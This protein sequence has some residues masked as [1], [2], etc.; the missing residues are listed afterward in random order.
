MQSD[1]NFE[2]HSSDEVM[3]LIRDIVMNENSDNPE[4]DED[5]CAKINKLGINAARRTVAKYRG[6]M[7]IPSS[8]KRK[9]ITKLKL[10]SEK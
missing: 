6:I 1:T 9:K 2:E 8:S 7:N 10:E 3:K 4:T 5:I